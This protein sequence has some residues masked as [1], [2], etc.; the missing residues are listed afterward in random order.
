MKSNQKTERLPRNE[1]LCR[2]FDIPVDALPHGYSLELQ[3]RSLLKLRGG[4]RILLYTP[5]EIRIALPRARGELLS[6]KGARLSCTS[7]N[8]GTL[9]IEGVISSVCF[10]RAGRS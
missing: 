3:G 5:E 1:R 2:L 9:G 8:K 4:G 10:E 6:I 7:Y